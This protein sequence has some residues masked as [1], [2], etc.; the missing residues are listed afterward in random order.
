[1]LE[2]NVSMAHKDSKLA[3]ADKLNNKSNLMKQRLAPNA[4]LAEMIYR[5][6]IISVIGESFTEGSLS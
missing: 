2:G 4:M 3:M 6:S 1:M 5:F